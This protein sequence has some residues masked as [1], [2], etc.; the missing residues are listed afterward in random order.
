MRKIIELSDAQN[1]VFFIETEINEAT[2]ALIS[3]GDAEVVKAVH[4]LEKSFEPII[5]LSKSIIQR[6][7]TLS[8]GKP[9]E[10]ELTFSIKLSGKLD[11][12]IVSADGEGSINLKLKWALT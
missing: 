8:I 12:W 10:L 11:F 6:V 2:L 1:H 3:S 9:S 4:S 7:N 5:N